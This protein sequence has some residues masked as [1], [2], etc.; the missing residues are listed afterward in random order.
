MVRRSRFSSNAV[1]DS[2]YLVPWLSAVGFPAYRPNELPATDS[3][4]QYAFILPGFF[5]PRVNRGE[6]RFASPMK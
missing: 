2:K 5:N 6:H 1:T 3:F 4:F